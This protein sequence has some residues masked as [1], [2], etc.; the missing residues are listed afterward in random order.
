V[1]EGE[2]VQVNVV[3]VG[4]AN[5][6]VIL[7]GLLEFNWW[8]NNLPVEKSVINSRLA[9]EDDEHRHVLFRGEFAGLGQVG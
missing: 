5:T 6:D 3:D 2:G 4:D 7:R 8:T 9:A 1:I